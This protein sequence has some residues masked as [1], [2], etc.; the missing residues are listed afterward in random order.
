MTGSK[1]HSRPRTRKT[2]SQGTVKSGS[3]PTR[4][5]REE[6]RAKVEEASRE[7]EEKR[8][9]ASEEAAEAREEAE[10]E[11]AAAREVSEES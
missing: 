1:R 6:S 11:S 10:E 5:V 2:H 3:T 4:V 9:Q 8:Q 7:A